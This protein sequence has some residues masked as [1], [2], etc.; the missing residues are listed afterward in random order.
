M[1]EFDIL[2]LWGMRATIALIWA[3]VVWV[4]VRTIKEM[5]K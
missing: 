2:I 3:C 5:M 4:F 1:K